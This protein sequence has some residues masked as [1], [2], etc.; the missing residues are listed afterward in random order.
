[1]KTKIKGGIISPQ[2]LSVEYIEKNYPSGKFVRNIPKKST[3]IK[4]AN[5]K[6]T[7]DVKALSA[8]EFLENNIGNGI[9]SVQEIRYDIPAQPRRKKKLKLTMR[10]F[11]KS[12]L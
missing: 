8:R 12:L 1:M 7:F 9:T 3:P 6:A 4:L 2:N 5:F 10:Q 11:K